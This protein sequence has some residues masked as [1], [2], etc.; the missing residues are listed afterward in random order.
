MEQYRFTVAE[1]DETE[2]FL[3]YHSLST[4][5]PRS[6]IA[7]FTNAE[8]ALQHIIA[9]GTDILITDHGMGT[10]SGTELISELRR[11]GYTFPII[12]VSGN[13]KAEEEARQ[14]GASAFLLKSADRK[15]VQNL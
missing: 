2:L 4:T 15:Q 9:T 14:A 7:S 6:N 12:M 13:P 1:D 10:M 3:L 5:Y 11:R 8:D